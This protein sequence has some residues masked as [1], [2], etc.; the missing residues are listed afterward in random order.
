MISGVTS[1]SIVTAF[2]YVADITAPEK[3]A[4]SFGLMGVAFGIGFIVGPALG[5]VL[6]GVSPRLPFWVA[7][8]LSLT[9][10]MYGLFILPESLAPERRAPFSWKRANPL[11][12]LRFLQSHPKLL[13]FASIHFL[14]NLAHQS[15]ASVFVLYTGYRY[16]LDDHRRRLRADRRSASA[17]PSSRADWSVRLVASFRRAA[18]ARRRPDLRRRRHVRS[19]AWR[20]P[21]V[22]F[23]V[24]IPIMSM[25]GLYGP[26][27]QG[28]MTR[29]VIR[30][31]R[32]DCRAR[33]AA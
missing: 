32:D 14:Y 18:D 28:L 1:A 4:K 31:N 17:S 27:A 13:G 29:R 5:G 10:G 11:G 3:R 16:R 30:L 26:S 19:T 2:A 33:S 8:G 7:A 24:G 6:S 22:W 20:Q 15:L 21:A 23:A 12:S 9:N 25:W